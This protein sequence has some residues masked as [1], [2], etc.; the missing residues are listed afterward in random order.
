MARS[1]WF[2][3]FAVITLLTGG[4]VVQ[5]A[6]PAQ[7]G[8]AKTSIEPLRVFGVGTVVPGTGSI[9]VRTKE[10]VGMTIHTFGLVPGNVYTPGSRSLIIRKGARPTLVARPTCRIPTCRLWGFGA[11]PNRR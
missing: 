4:L 2:T 5:G 3:F 1:R 7:A 8:S 10:G 11:Q 6:R 9:L